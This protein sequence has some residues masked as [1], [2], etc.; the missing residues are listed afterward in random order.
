MENQNLNTKQNYKGWKDPGDNRSGR[1][2]G[3]LVLVLIGVV[4]LA[5][6]MNALFL[7]HWVFSWQMLLIVIGL[8][9]GFRHSFRKPGWIVLVIIGTVFLIDDFIPEI[10]FRN[11]FWPILIIGI[12]LWV[13][14]KPKGGYTRHYRPTAPTI[15]PIN[16]P[17]GAP[18]E[19]TFS[20][21]AQATSDDYVN[22]TAIFGGVKRNILSKN[23]KGGEIVS[24]FGGNELNLTQADIHHPVVLDT[25]QIFG[26]TS[27]IIPPHWEVRNEVVAIL[28]GVSD[29]RVMLP[30]GYDPNKVLVI[31][32]T[33][34]FGGLDIKSY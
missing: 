25:T 32:G 14:L 15:P 13:I 12:G 34:L 6:K 7:P 4:L 17:A 19:R 24:V 20:E 9:I 22:S 5:Y 28:G 33:A 26:G 11:Y 27:L 31:K 10:A 23:F 1:V 2:M 16:M 8:F 29:K 3:G 21:S 30:G 18:T